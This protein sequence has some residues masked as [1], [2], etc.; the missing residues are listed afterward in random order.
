MA[1]QHWHVRRRT[2][3]GPRGTFR[4]RC[5]RIGTNVIDVVTS[6]RRSHTRRTTVRI[7]NSTRTALL[8]SIHSPVRIAACMHGLLEVFLCNSLIMY[9]RVYRDKLQDAGLVEGR[10]REPGMPKCCGGVWSARHLNANAVRLR[11]L[12]VIY[13]LLA[14]ALGIS[15]SVYLFIVSVQGYLNPSLQSKLQKWPVEFHPLCLASVTT[16]STL[17][18]SKSRMLP[19]ASR[20]CLKCSPWSKVLNPQT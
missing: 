18:N 14:L 2:S 7:L 6:R 15:I 19:A 11:R 13:T 4:G 10:G 12:R 8:S 9:L 5:A 20:V 17:Y 3:G 16:Y 1:A